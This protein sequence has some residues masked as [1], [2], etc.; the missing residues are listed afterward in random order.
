MSILIGG[1]LAIGVVILVWVLVLGL[2]AM[3]E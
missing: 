1:A 3:S 2:L